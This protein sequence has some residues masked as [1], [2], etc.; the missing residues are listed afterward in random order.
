MTRTRRHAV[1]LLVLALLG[2]G[3]TPV[4]VAPTATAA[5]DSAPVACL[6]YS[7]DQLTPKHAQLRTINLRTGEVKALGPALEGLQIAGLAVQ[8]GSLALYAVANVAQAPISR[9]YRV[10]PSSGGLTPLGETGLFR[11]SGLAFHPSDGTLWTWVEGIGLATLDPGSGAG[12]LVVRK[13]VSLKYLESLAWAPDGSTL[14]GA[15]G[16]TIWSL[17]R[18]SATMR[19]AAT[20]L[21]DF[22]HALAMRPDGQIIRV[23]QAPGGMEFEVYSLAEQRVTASFPLASRFKN[24]E[25]LAWPL[26]CGTPSPGGE[27]DMNLSV[28]VD[29]QQICANESVIVTATARHPESPAGRVDISTNGAWGSPQ[30]LTFSGP[31]GPRVI[32][33]NA[34]TPDKFTDSAQTIIEVV[35][36]DAAHQVLEVTS[37]PNPFREYVIDFGIANAATFAGQSPSYTWDFGDGQTSVTSDPAMAHDY[38]AALP[39][40][41]LYATF[42]VAVTLRRDGQPELRAA[43]TVTLWNTYAYNKRL[44]FLQP[45]VEAPQQLQPV[46]GGLGA[47]IQIRNL[48]DEPIRFGSRQ[49][50]YQRCD[51]STLSVPPA[52]EPVTIEVGA[53]QQL[54]HQLD[55][56]A[57]NVTD[58]ICG[59]A[60]ALIGQSESGLPAYAT[61]YFDVRPNALVAHQVTDPALL[62][63]LNQVS[64][65]GL[66]PD[67]L[68]VTEEEL[69]RLARLQKIALAPRQPDAVVADMVQPQ[70]GE[71]LLGQPCVVGSPSP[72]PGVVCQP[73][74]EWTVVPPRIANAR[75][76]D[77]I[78]TAGCGPI[79]N[80]LRQ[81]WPPQRYSHSGLMVDDYYHIRH[82]TAADERYQAERYLEGLIFAGT[83]GIRSDIIQYGWPGIITQSVDEAYNGEVMLDPESGDRYTIS[84]F[85]NQPPSCDENAFP[86]VVGPPPGAAPEV[87]ARLWQAA[88][89]ARG[90]SGHYRFY[91]YTDANIAGNDAFKAPASAGWAA[92][93]SAT[94]CSSFIWH[95]LHS[96]GITLEGDRIELD[97]ALQGAERDD[98][99]VDGLYYYTIAERKAGSAWMY[100]Y[101]YNEAQEKLHETLGPILGPF[102]E[103][104]SGA[105]DDVGNQITNCFGFDQCGEKDEPLWKDPGVGRAV[106]PDNIM[107]WDSPAEGG[108][109]GYNER[110][111]YRGAE[112]AQLSRWAAA[113]DVGT[114]TGRVRFQGQPVGGATVRFAG[115]ELVTNAGGTFSDNL[116]P[117]GAYAIV[118]SAGSG[119]LVL[120]GHANVTVTPGGASD[121]E[122]TM[123]P[124]PVYNRRVF[125]R[126]SMYIVDHETFGDNEVGTFTIDEF[127][128]LDPFNRRADLRISHCVGAEVRVELDVQLRLE[129]DNVT[130]AASGEARL[131]EGASCGTDDREDSATFL[132]PTPPDE[133]KSV[134]LR[135]RNS[136]FG[137]GDTA[138]LD[139]VVLNA[140]R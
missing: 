75:K 31:P 41:E 3:L 55:L 103:P 131:Y 121:V 90:I 108:V 29:R 17:D 126:G 56:P 49:I 12:A 7:S 46:A 61:A 37:Q 76:G 51:P 102:G 91:A 111:D 21:H 2:L 127:R 64:A 74:G 34:V 42:Q 33:V 139:F 28:D 58:A 94:V 57:A 117:A 53:G 119:N 137:G 122:V 133:S 45:P 97:D 23:T 68:H 114:V 78:L 130:V 116:V 69:Y 123:T 13:P 128:D 14:Y 95:A 18:A 39:R 52:P 77:T 4:G 107:F 93:T 112:Y 99:T 30:A 100:S 79:G 83:D 125:V 138:D 60:V 27:A 136:G 134:G 115:L 110:L 43:Q 6:N 35:A 67:R 26:E 71:D 105:A 59:V 15:E 80:L 72:R 36:C 70:A 106:S 104:F 124:L 96:S 47:A 82:A 11:V 50:E 86:L 62:Q 48:E 87:R 44:G 8:P 38:R 19:R 129:D 118:V 16:T 88:E 32:Q 22:A 24:M 92:G 65:Q 81:V 66:T 9:L 63:V 25:A 135:L 98:A 54:V 73:S 140:R 85:S 113:P 132:T 10:D 109:Y 120:E 5:S 89:A 84:G 20:G 1:A 40:D 101:F